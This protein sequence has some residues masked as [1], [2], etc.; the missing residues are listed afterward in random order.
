MQIRTPECIQSL[1]MTDSSCSFSS[2]WKP[3]GS[4]YALETIESE[5]K[6]L[7]DTGEDGGL[8]ELAHHELLHLVL[9]VEGGGLLVEPVALL[10]HERAVQVERKA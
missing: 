6:C 2:L 10:H 7:D 1:F 9:G 5:H 8:N 3:I 4:D